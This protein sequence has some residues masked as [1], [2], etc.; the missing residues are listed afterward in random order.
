MLEKTVNVY[1]PIL[2]SSLTPSDSI[3]RELLIHNIKSI[4]R[5]YTKALHLIVEQ[6]EDEKFDI[7]HQDLLKDPPMMS[8]WR[9]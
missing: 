8:L 4:S 2:T 7:I 3:N 6:S 1:N 9:N 5:D